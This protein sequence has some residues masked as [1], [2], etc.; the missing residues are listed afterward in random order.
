MQL[1][2]GRYGTLNFVFLLKSNQILFI[3]STATLKYNIRKSENIVLNVAEGEH[4]SEI[5]HEHNTF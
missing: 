4:E 1:T 2:V 3:T 5:S